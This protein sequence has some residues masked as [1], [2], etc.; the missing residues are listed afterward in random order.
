M[1]AT[2]TTTTTRDSPLE[3]TLS[4]KTPKKT[5]GTVSLKAEPSQQRLEKLKWSA[6]KNLH[7][8]VHNLNYGHQTKEIQTTFG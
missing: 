8:K 5:H 4:P 2:T 6:A 1:A 7:T 3:K